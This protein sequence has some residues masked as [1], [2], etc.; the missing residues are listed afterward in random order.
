MDEDQWA[1]GQMPAFE[2]ELTPHLDFTKRVGASAPHQYYAS[3]ITQNAF[4]GWL[5]CVRSLTC[6]AF[7]DSRGSY[8]RAEMTPEGRVLPHGTA[9]Y[10]LRSVK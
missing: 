3:D 8:P 6:A 10:A 1:A 2:R 4:A 5:A 7:V 9:L